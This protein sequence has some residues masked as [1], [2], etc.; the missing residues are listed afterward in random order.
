MDNELSMSQQQALVAKK[1]NDIMRLIRK[2]MTGRLREVH[3]CPG[4][5]SPGV[6]YP[7]LGS[8]VQER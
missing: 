6:L 7:V 8:L 5:A 4:E 2:S 3:L 1:A